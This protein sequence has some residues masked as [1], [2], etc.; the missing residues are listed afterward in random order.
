VRALKE[1]DLKP[2]RVIW[3]TLLNLG[4]KISIEIIMISSR[5]VGLMKRSPFMLN[6]PLGAK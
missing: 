2:E 6:T 5:L 1:L 4:I 3:I